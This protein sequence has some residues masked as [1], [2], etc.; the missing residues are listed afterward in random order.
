M[1]NFEMTTIEERKS[2]LKKIIKFSE[3]S[4]FHRDVLFIGSSAGED[5]NGTDYLCFVGSDLV[6]FTE[7]TFYNCM[8]C[9]ALNGIN[10]DI[11]YVLEGHFDW[12]YNYDMKEFEY[13]FG[14]DS[15]F[16]HYIKN[17]LTHIIKK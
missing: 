3:I 4:F 6:H 12:V 13:D 14:R 5:Y 16:V 9:F 2:M 11:D 8:T 17:N 15:K 1:K 10:K 7:R